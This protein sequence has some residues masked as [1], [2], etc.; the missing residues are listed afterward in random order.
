MNIKQMIQTKELS[1]VLDTV[2]SLHTENKFEESLPLLEKSLSSEAMFDDPNPTNARIHF[3]YLKAIALDMTGKLEEAFSIF[4]QLVTDYPGTPKFEHSIKIVCNKLEEAAKGLI[5]KDPTDKAIKEILRKLEKHTF[6][7]YWLIHTVASQEASE[8][9][10]SGAWKRI[11]ALLA[12]S[13]NDA[14]YLRLA[15]SLADSCNRAQEK[16]KLLKHIESLL[17][18]RP[19]RLDLV[20]LLEQKEAVFPSSN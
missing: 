2:G 17:D 18:E 13:P 8:G 1:D 5:K 9:N 12:L 10:V 14:D 19:Y 7:A 4:D 6:P 20:P 15:L 3:L 16:R 11:E